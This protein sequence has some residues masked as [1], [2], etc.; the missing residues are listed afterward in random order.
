MIDWGY[1]AGFTDADGHINCTQYKGRINPR[2]IISQKIPDPLV[3]IQEFLGSGKLREQNSGTLY[4]L[5]HEGQEIYEPLTKIAPM[6]IVK[7]H[8][9]SRVLRYLDHRLT[10]QRSSHRSFDPIQECCRE[11]LH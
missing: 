7:A 9:A 2:W 5:V 3:A 8:D 4:H 11:V 6:L 10:H 1:V